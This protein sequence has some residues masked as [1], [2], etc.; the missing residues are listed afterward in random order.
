MYIYIY[1]YIYVW[2]CVD[3][4]INVTDVASCL[5]GLPFRKYKSVLIS[6][7]LWLH[8]SSLI[9]IDRV[10]E[11]ISLLIFLVQSYKSRNDSK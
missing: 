7:V 5:H 9:S 4:F 2:V 10:Q 8:V 3:I 11:D 1:M 6:V